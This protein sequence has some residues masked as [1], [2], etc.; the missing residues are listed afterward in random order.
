MGGDYPGP[1]KMS[2]VLG[3][4]KDYL[5]GVIQAISG[6]QMNVA[7]TQAE[8]DAAVSPIYAKSQADLYD[9]QGRRINQIGS[10]I[11]TA[12]QLAASER[13]KK[14]GEQY[15]GDLVGLADKFQR[16]LDP[17][18]YKT[19]ET[20]SNAQNNL[21]N[22]MDPN[23]L[24]ANEREEVARGLVQMGATNNPNDAQGTVANAATFG[25]ALQ[26]KQN[27]FANVVNNVAQTLPATKSGIT[28]FE[29]ATRRAL[30]PNTGDAKFTGVQQNTGQNAWN[31]G[32]NFM[33]Q[34]ANLQAIKA[35]KSKDMMDMVQQGAQTASSMTSA[36]GGM[37][38][39]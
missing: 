2:A 32:N 33:N 37:M 35:Q 3:A 9:T 17:E 21:I 26:A 36:L 34:A 10:E 30:T 28:G 24:S 5:P 29:V 6:E 14:I 31:T 20:V 38:S 18:F 8:V 39:F 12:N 25:G 19:R 13:E 11:E 7:K 4:M 1:E 16:Q 23:K 15:G 22:S 27:N